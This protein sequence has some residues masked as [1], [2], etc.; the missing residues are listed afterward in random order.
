MKKVDIYIEDRHYEVHDGHIYG[1]HS[2][3]PIGDLLYIVLQ[4]DKYVGPITLPEKAEWI[5]RSG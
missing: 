2:K 3:M 4:Y 1:Y 5:Y